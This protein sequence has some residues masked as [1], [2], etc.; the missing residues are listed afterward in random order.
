MK[1]KYLLSMLSIFTV[2]TFLLLS[3]NMVSASIGNLG[4]F[5]VNSCITLLQTC[6]DCTYNNIS[7]VIQPDGIRGLSVVTTMTKSGTEYTYS[8]CNTSKAGTY[9]V[10]G[11]GD[12]GT[13][14]TKWNYVFEVT[15]NGSTLSN[16]QTLLYFIPLFI[17]GFL[18]FFLGYRFV[19]SPTVASKSVYFLLTY[20][21]GL[22]PFTYSI[23]QLVNDYLPMQTFMINLLYYFFFIILILTP[24]VFLICVAYMIIDLLNS[25][26]KKTLV[27]RG[28]SESEANSRIKKHR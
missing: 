14:L 2:L 27:S 28:H 1:N 9:N 17:F 16:S 20:I 13:V 24:V 26:A 18:V 23:Y 6:A 19:S 25:A 12:P 22:L 15:P 10:N 11:Y 7:S 5:K 4:T 8:F 3:V 21:I